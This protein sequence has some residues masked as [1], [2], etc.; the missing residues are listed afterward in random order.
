[1]AS[2][3]SRLRTL[4]ALLAAVGLLAASWFGGS[5][6]SARAAVGSATGPMIGDSA[7]DGAVL[8]ASGLAPGQSRSG[9]V[10][11]SN[12]G[13][14]GGEFTLSSRD[15]VDTTPTTPLSGVLD[16]VVADVTGASPALVYSGRL[17]D[18]GAVALGTLAQGESRRYRFTVAFPAGRS[19][20][21]DDPYQGASSS[22]TFA[23]TVTG[24]EPA[25][26]SAPDHTVE[27]AGT[28]SA[29]VTARPSLSARARQ[30]GAHGAIVARVDCPTDCRATI[31]GSATVG[32][33]R[34]T[35]APISL[36]VK[37]GRARVRVALPRRARTAVSAGGA[38]IVR[39]RLSATAGGRVV[40]A[41][42]TVRVARAGH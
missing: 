27:A 9:E 13:D 10:T 20:V 18:L 1:M 32:R 29:I 38:A 34:S 8:T 35:L 42:R 37:T 24:A 11:V 30:T 40:T 4:P 15:L 12:V 28:P 39:L 41:S 5:D 14:E 3:R 2:L 26:A 19:P 16:L 33:A 23:W 25:G 36:T 22:V 31:T 7:G 21:L 17:T 6:G